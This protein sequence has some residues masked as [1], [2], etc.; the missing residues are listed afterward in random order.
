MPVSFTYVWRKY[1][2]LYS[3]ETSYPS[4]YK[5]V[6]VRAS[7]CSFK[8]KEVEAKAIRDVVRVAVRA[9]SGHEI[10]CSIDESF[11]KTKPLQASQQRC[12]CV[13]NLSQIN[14]VSYS[15]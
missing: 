1:L 6:Y 7:E 11:Q 2:G 9:F 10:R 15:R 12:V 3:K 8:A 14:G 5:C 13:H 4:T